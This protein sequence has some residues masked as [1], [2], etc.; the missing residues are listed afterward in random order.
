MASAIVANNQ[1]LQSRS[2]K[3]HRPRGPLTLC[4]HDAN[5]LIQTPTTPN[6][7][8]DHLR[9]ENHLAV[10]AQNYTGSL[11]FDLSRVLVW[12]GRFLPVGFYYIAFFKPRGIWA[13]WEPIVRKAAGLGVSNLKV[14]APYNDKTYVF[15]DIAVVG[16]GPAGLN[17]ALHAANSG[18]KVVLIEQEPHLGDP[19]LP[20]LCI[21]IITECHPVITKNL[22]QVLT[23]NLGRGLRLQQRSA[24]TSLRR[25]S[26]TQTSVFSALPPVMHGLPTT[27]YR[28]YK[29]RD[30]SSSERN[31]PF[32]LLD[33][34]NSTS[35]F[36]TMI[37][38]AWLCAAHSIALRAF[39]VSFRQRLSPCS[40]VM[41][42][43]IVPRS[44]ATMAA[45]TLRQLST[46][47][48]A[49]MTL[50]CLKKHTQEASLY[51]RDARFMK[52]QVAPLGMRCRR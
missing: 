15:C 46:Y 8:A 52:P 11:N 9:A 50:H 43:R 5:T 26:L 36:A 25:S 29:A 31:K 32:L 4:G 13:Y 6:L 18:A 48:I 30:S 37:C 20:R 33:L 16:A 10:S 34:A 7:L 44:V 38:Q 12:F 51:S 40:P 17:A 35:S 39:T 24:T 28:S 21:L 23:Q 1:W 14:K 45:Q 2:F 22:T 42:M 41:I 3:Y 27:I 19:Q 47:V 49:A